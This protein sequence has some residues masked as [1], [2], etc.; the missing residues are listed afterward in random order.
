MNA[1]VVVATLAGWGLCAAPAQGDL[2]PCIAAHGSLQ[3]LFTALHSFM[4][5]LLSSFAWVAV[6]GHLSGSVLQRP[7]LH[8]QELVKHYAKYLHKAASGKVAQ[9]VTAMYE[10]GCADDRIARHLF[11]CIL[12]MLWAACEQ[13]DQLQLARP[14][15]HLLTKMSDKAFDE[16]GSTEM[17]PSQ[18]NRAVPSSKVCPWPGVAAECDACALT[19]IP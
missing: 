18:V 3:A 1:N 14:V 9:L 5:T 12:P 11:V 4:S 16:P 13:Q 15:V 10:C 6:S 2:S 8:L 17:H 7:H 19:L